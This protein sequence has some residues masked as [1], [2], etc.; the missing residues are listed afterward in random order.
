MF[1]SM[2]PPYAAAILVKTEPNVAVEVLG[3]MNKSKAGKVMAAMAPDRA[4]WF[5]DQ[6]GGPPLKVELP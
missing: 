5:A 4:A 1:E 6:I 3:R 2:R